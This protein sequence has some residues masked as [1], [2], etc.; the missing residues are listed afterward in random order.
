VVKVEE[1][2]IINKLKQV[3]IEKANS[4]VSLSQNHHLSKNSIPPFLS[5]F[6]LKAYFHPSSDQ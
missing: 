2:L 4:Q 3:F 1:H 6:S 5:T